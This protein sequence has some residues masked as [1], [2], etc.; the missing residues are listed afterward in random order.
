[1]KIEFELTLDDLVAF[2]VVHALRSPTFKRQQLG[3]FVGGLLLFSV[4]PGL[5]LATTEKPVLETAR[6][7][8]PLLMG[9]ISYL[10]F[11]LVIPIW[12]KR[13]EAI[14]KRMLAEGHNS[15]ADGP[16]SL[17]IE[18]DGLRETR[19]A[20]ESLRHWSAVE[21]VLVTDTHAFVYTSA[22]EAFESADGF[23]QFVG[24]LSERAGVVPEVV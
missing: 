8:W 6:D 12:R 20:G 14:S 17:T 10:L 13:F 24:E 15:G 4:L 7:I 21:K 5:I 1:M 3:Y 23:Q 16:C 9:P 2:T 19:P 11:M 22:V 18:S